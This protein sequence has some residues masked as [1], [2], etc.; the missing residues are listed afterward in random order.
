MIARKIGERSQKKQSGLSKRG[1]SS[2]DHDAKARIDGARISG[3]DASL[4]GAMRNHRAHAQHLEDKLLS[5]RKPL[6]RKEGLSLSGGMYVPD[7]SF[8]E[9]IL[10][11]GTYSLEVP[12]LSVRA[13]AH[14]AITGKKRVS[15][16]DAIPPT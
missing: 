4:D 11:A 13:G 2:K 5:V 9:S 6:M 3:K 12:S 1:I 10:R 15:P 8:P 16:R 7:I 14:I